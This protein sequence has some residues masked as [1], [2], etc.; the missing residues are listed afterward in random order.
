MIVGGLYVSSEFPELN[1]K[2]H[3]VYT[4]TT[5]RIYFY[6]FLNR[7]HL[8][9]GLVNFTNGNLQEIPTGNGK[10]QMFSPTIKAHM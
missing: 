1:Q 6:F 4:C 2:L 5:Y 10:Q 7:T 3:V 9:K 8:H